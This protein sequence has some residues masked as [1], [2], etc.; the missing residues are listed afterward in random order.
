MG[1]RSRV[2]RWEGTREEGSGLGER[3]GRQAW[4]MVGPRLEAGAGAEE[5]WG[6]AQRE[7]YEG[8]SH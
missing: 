1:P 8:H 6:W 2:R 3:F 5:Q 4:G 7:L